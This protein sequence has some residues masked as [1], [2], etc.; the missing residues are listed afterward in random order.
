MKISFNLQSSSLFCEELFVR[1]YGGGT[2]ADD[3]FPNCEAFI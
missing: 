2:K 1:V 3:D